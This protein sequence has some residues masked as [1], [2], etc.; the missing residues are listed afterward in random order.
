MSTPTQKTCEDVAA[1]L[2]VPLAR[3]VK[4]IVVKGAEGGLVA[5]ALRADHALNEVKAGKH[6]RI[7]APLALATDE[8]IRAA[9]GC[10]PGFL[11]PVGCKVPVIADHAAARLAD[12]VCGANATGFHLT[13]ANWARD[14]AE[15]ETADLRN[16]V[17]G[18]P[19][20]DGAGMLTLTR[21]IEVGHI[22]QNG[23]LYTK[24]LGVTVLGEDGKEFTPT[25]GCYGIGVT[26]VVAA[27]I[28]QRN[29]ARGILWPDSIAPFRVLIC[30]IGYGKSE[31]VRRAADALYD[32]LA[33]AG[34]DV[35]LDDRDLRPGPMFADA[36]LI[37]IPHRVVIGAKG[38]A[39]GQYE[40]KRRD[41]AEP[42]MID[43]RSAAVL[44]RLG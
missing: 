33:A 13:G 6:P 8:E 39:N 44:A 31:E 24:A 27:A 5:V 40:Y 32:A 38:L 41:A 11:G 1:F 43:A 26:R 36:D 42:E 17:E 34:V 10:E 12:F 21:G 4:F 30:P 16:V 7:A 15:P 23:P 22:F 35:A 9:F 3:L 29:D 25:A 28:E 20:P 18:D 37:G 2:G 19:S 14:A